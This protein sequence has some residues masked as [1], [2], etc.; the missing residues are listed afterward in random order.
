MVRVTRSAKKPPEPALVLGDG[1][2]LPYDAVT[3]TFGVLAVRGAGKT[4]LTAV[5]VEEMIS[6]GL[7]VVVVDPVG[8]WWG[9]RSSSDGKAPGLPVVI[10]G[11]DHGDLPLGAGPG[12]G[13]LVADFVVESRRPVVIDLSLFRKGEQTRF[14]TDFAETL[15]RRNRAPLHLVIDEADAVAPQRP[16]PGEQRLLGAIEDLVRRGRARG[17]G[18]TLVT[19]RA[20]VLNKN[21]LTQISTLVCLRMASPQDRDAI[22]D[23]IRAHGSPEQRETMMASLASLPIGTAWFWSPGWLGVFQR[24]QIRKRRTFDSSATPDVTGAA[25]PAPALAPVDLDAL[26][27]RMAEML[28]RVEAEDP[29]ALK[30]KVAAL[31]RELAE[32]RAKLAEKPAPAPALPPEHVFAL[33]RLAELLHQS[34]VT[35]LIRALGTYRKPASTSS[36]G[37]PARPPREK[38]RP[39]AVRIHTPAP[40]PAEPGHPLADAGIKAGARRMLLRL[41]QFRDRGGLTRIQLGTLAGVS[42]STGTFTEYLSALRKN[43]LVRE[44][45]GRLH[46]TEPGM[47]HLPPGLPILDAADLRALWSSRLKAGAR[48]MLDLVVASPAGIGRTELGERAGVS[49]STGTFTE[50]LSSLRRPGLVVVEGQVVRQGPAFDVLVE[51]NKQQAGGR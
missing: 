51:A 41:A 8:V 15:Y 34:W 44:E 18:V 30:K 27:T 23:W 26:R 10:L 16:Q 14:M 31:T 28:A 36:E 32:A 37:P 43:G 38:P 40:P 1:L 49:S 35:D 25:A 11:G 50:Y 33:E 20:A 42:S 4:Y 6:A 48:R 46:I 22:D 47:A 24:V 29:A 7:P 45:D 13:A 19:Q 3:Q 12:A 2:T 39:A 21:V 9:L 17:L 5:M